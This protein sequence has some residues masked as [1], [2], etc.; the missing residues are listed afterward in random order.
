MISP[1][2]GPSTAKGEVLVR[3]KAIG[4]NRAEFY[5]MRGLWKDVAAF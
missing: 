5:M 1:L 4:V 2:P 3:V